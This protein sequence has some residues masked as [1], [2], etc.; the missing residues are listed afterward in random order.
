MKSNVRFALILRKK[1]ARLDILQRP[2]LANKILYIQ[3]SCKTDYYHIVQDVKYTR[4]GK[5]KPTNENIWS[6]SNVYYANTRG[7]SRSQNYPIK[8][9]PRKTE[10]LICGGLKFPRWGCA[11]AYL[12]PRTLHLFHDVANAVVNRFERGIGVGF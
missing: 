6:A 4:Q 1:K 3:I 11:N 12:Y 2:R 9:R 10:I 8:N 5:I 7:L